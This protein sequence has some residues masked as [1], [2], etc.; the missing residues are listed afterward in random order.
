M[1]ITNGYATL[2]DLKIRLGISTTDSNRDAAL[3]QMIEASSRQ[4]DGWTAR[5]FYTQT[6]ARILT[7]AYPD[8]LELDK[9]LISITTLE[10]D[11]YGDRVFET[12]WDATDY[13]LDGDTPYRTV[14]LA[15]GGTRA[16][17]TGRRRVRITGAWGYA[18]TVPAPIR[19]ATLLMS[20]RLY[21]RKDAPFGVAGS[22][23]HGQ[24]QTISSIDP[25]VKQLIQQ[26]RWFGVV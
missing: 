20:A 6:A 24:L 5:T 7:A 17:P 21:K 14:F 25:D 8:V 18:T 26:F 22:A 15:P 3:E 19:E 12:T 1:A 16:F 23:E 4:I 13:E 10:T 11:E 2:S 9:D